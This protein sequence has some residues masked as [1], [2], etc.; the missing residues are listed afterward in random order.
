MEEKKFNH[1]ILTD[2][3]KERAHRIRTLKPISRGTGL[4]ILEIQNKE[5]SE[6]ENIMYTEVVN[7]EYLER[8]S[9]K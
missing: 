8:K 4:K 9:M 5:S 7:K 6:L 3:T 1:L 2:K